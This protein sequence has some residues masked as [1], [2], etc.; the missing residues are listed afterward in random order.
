VVGAKNFPPILPHVQ[1]PAEPL[2]PAFFNI[3]GQPFQITNTLV[4]TLIADIFIL[5]IAFLIRK[6]ILSGK[7]VVEGVSG[8]FALLVEMLYGL[9]ESTAGKYT[10]KIFPYFATI[11]LLVL[12]VNWM[13]LLPGV[14][15]IGLLH[16][17]EHGYPIQEIIPGVTTLI[18]GEDSEG[19]EGEHGEETLYGIYPF[20]RVASTDLNFTVGLAIVSVTMTQVLGLQVLGRGYLKKYWNTDGLRKAFKERNFGDPMAFIISF[21]NW[22]V[23][24]LEVISE[25]SKIISFAFRLFGVIFAGSVL[26]FVLGT[27]VPVFVQAPFYLLEMFFGILQAFVFGILTMMF[28][29]NATKSHGHD[30]DDEH[31]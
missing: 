11:F 4:A 2:T 16:K 8:V 31:Q 17:D 7:S 19:H 21:F 5:I 22:V 25:G 30:D 13:E 26:L 24:L 1:L 18:R 15:S 10:K 20:V 9:T 28:M 6:Q 14:D 23:G 3:L 12:T 29:T 27:L